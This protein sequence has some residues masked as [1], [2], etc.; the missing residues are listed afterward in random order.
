MD[1]RACKDNND[2]KV[3]EIGYLNGRSNIAFQ[4]P[5]KN[6]VHLNRPSK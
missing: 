5:L 4:T 2:P 3:L 6:V 1:S